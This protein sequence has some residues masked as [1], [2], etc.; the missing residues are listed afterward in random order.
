MTPLTAP[1][2]AIDGLRFMRD[3]TRGGLATVAHEIAAA[4][5]LS[6]RLAEARIPVRDAVR[7]FCHILGYDPY[8]LASEGRVVAVA[9]PDAAERDPALWRAMPGG[10]QAS[11]IGTC[12]RRSPAASFWRRRSAANAFSRNSKTIRC[13]E[14]AE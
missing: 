8:Y 4:T 9:A 7:S 5:R 2:A 10:E 1:L 11:V 12:R 3:P 14:F 6:V 13:R